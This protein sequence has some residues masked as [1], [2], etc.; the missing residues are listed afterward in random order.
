LLLRTPLGTITN[1]ELNAAR[2]CWNKKIAWE[3]KKFNRSLLKVSTAQLTG[4]NDQ[5]KFNI[6]ASI[7]M[8]KIDAPSYQMRNF[9]AGSWMHYTSWMV[10]KSHSALKFDPPKQKESPPDFEDDGTENDKPINLPKFVAGLHGCRGSELSNVSSVKAGKKCGLRPG[11][12]PIKAR[13]AVTPAAAQ[14]QKNHDE[15]MAY[16]GCLVAAAEELAYQSKKKT[17]AANIFVWNN[18]RTSVFEMAY[19]GQKARGLSAGEKRKH[20]ELMRSMVNFEDLDATASLEFKD[21]NPQFLCLEP[22]TTMKTCLLWLEFKVV[23][24]VIIS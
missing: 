20:V 4:V 9:P 1:R 15:K 16:F 6:A 17:S 24:T 13:E 11:K 10:L 19:F 3:V 2:T 12:K 22:T 5:Q 23:V 21:S 14:H 7:T 18:G 8:G